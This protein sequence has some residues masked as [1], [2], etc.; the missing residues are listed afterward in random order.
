MAGATG[1]PASQS[2]I[3]NRLIFYVKTRLP[4]FNTTTILRAGAANLRNSFTGIELEAVINAYMSALKDGWIYS[5]AFC[6]VAFLIAFSLQWKSGMPVSE[7][8]GGE[9]KA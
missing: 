3:D 9:E 7:R 8:N 4:T 1:V 5:I 6:G 2:V